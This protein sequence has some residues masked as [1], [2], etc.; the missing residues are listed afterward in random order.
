MLA[1]E[2]EG[3]QGGHRSCPTSPS[4]R[5]GGGQPVDLSALRG[6]LVINLW[7]SWCGPCREE[8]PHYQAFSKKYAGKVDVLGVDWQD[9]R[10][11]RPGR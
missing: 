1:S 5:F 3:H 10:A 9:T 7:A 2:T 4:S 11:A 8:L 6:P